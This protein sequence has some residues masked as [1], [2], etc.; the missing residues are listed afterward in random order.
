VQYGMHVDTG[1]SDSKQAGLAGLFS[2]AHTPKVE[3]RVA[4]CLV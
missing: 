3:C 4:P 1:S 2:F